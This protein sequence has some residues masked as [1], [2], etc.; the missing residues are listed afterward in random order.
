MIVVGLLEH[1]DHEGPAGGP[2]LVE[3]GGEGGGVG[4]GDGGV[5]AQAGAGA[6]PR[7]QEPGEEGV[8]GEGGA[9]EQHGDS[10]YQQKE[11]GSK[12]QV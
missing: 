1:G 3:G 7:P 12:E 6:A 9:E 5:P 8:D 11:R 2:G 4:G 10:R